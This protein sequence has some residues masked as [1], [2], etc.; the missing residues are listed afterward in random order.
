MNIFICK[1][2]G[3]I[4]WF[5][6]FC[7]KK[8]LKKEKKIYMEH[9]EQK[10][11]NEN[12]DKINASQAHWYG[13]WCC[14]FYSTLIKLIQTHAIVLFKTI[15]SQFTIDFIVIKCLTTISSFATHTKMLF[16]TRMYIKD[17]C[18]TCQWNGVPLTLI[19]TLLFFFLRFL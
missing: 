1:T 3:S 2:E 15:N 11:C 12:H 4:Q 19:K 14:F 17:V 13:C 10:F 7:S 9:Q 5:E 18:I 8:K 16:N 6:K